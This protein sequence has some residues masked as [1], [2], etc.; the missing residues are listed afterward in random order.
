[1]VIGLDGT[2]KFAI[3]LA[4]ITQVGALLTVGITLA[5]HSRREKRAFLAQ[6]RRTVYRDVY[7]VISS[8]RPLLAFNLERLA[9]ESTGVASDDAVGKEQV[10]RISELCTKLESGTFDVQLVASTGCRDATTNLAS[11]LQAAAIL[12]SAFDMVDAEGQA[13]LRVRAR[14]ELGQGLA[15]D[16]SNLTGWRVS[17]QV[18]VWRLMRDD[19]I[20]RGVI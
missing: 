7:S 17:E 16:P 2:Q 13:E 20:G 3:W 11:H 4:L 15:G 10:A 18:R 14:K 6:E 9:N 1:M 12:L 19:I 5:G 8:L